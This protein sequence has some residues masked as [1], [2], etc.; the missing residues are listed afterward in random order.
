MEK[1]ELLKISELADFFGTTP[2]ALRLYEK[3]GILVPC[4]KLTELV[5]SL[6]LVKLKIIVWL[7][8]DLLVCTFLP[9]FSTSRFT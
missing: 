7:F 1:D 2:K 9:L 4:K 3:K 5:P 8:D 6:L